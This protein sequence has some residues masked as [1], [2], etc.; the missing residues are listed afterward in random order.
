MASFATWVDLRRF[1]KSARL[2]LQRRYKAAHS[3]FKSRP[4]GMVIRLLAPN[5]GAC[6]KKSSSASSSLAC[7]RR[8]K[9]VSSSSPGFQ[10]A[11]ASP[12]KMMPC[13][14]CA[15][16]VPVRWHENKSAAVWPSSGDGYHIGQN[17]GF[18]HGRCRVAYS[19]SPRVEHVLR[20]R[21]DPCP[22]DVEGFC[23]GIQGHFATPYVCSEQMQS[24]GTVAPGVFYE[25]GTHGLLKPRWLECGLFLGPSGWPSCW[26]CHRRLLSMLLAVASPGHVVSIDLPLVLFSAAQKERCYCFTVSEQTRRRCALQAHRPAERVLN[27][28]SNIGLNFLVGVEQ[29]R[30]RPGPFLPNCSDS[31]EFRLSSELAC[32]LSLHRPHLWATNHS[33]ISGP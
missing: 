9:A 14:S 21:L 27:S 2:T 10:H 16:G 8:R 23:P 4:L 11:E 33:H 1:T 22:S 31:P 7:M 6:L 32:N 29:H 13:W 26:S 15:R 24:G 28:P 30:V 12:P 3:I 18:G 19:F 5:S 17:A 20:P 25:S